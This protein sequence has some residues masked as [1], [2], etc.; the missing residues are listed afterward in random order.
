MNAQVTWTPRT[1]PNPDRYSILTAPGPTYRAT[2]ESVVG[3]VAAGTE[4]F[5]T[6]EGLAAPGATALYKVYVVLTTLNERGSN[7]VSVTRPG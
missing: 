4:E 5:S 7:T 2:A 6:N 1:N 3:T